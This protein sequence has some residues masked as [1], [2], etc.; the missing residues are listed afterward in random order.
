MS[1]GNKIEGKRGAGLGLKEDLI[2]RE[3]GL[4]KTVKACDDR[5]RIIH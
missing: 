2:N 4:E 5:C 3:I 1:R